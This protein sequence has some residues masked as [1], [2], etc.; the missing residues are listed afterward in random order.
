[1]VILD[2]ILPVKDTLNIPSESAET[3]ES[4]QAADDRLARGDNPYFISYI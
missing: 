3:G 4:S 2:Q 1:M